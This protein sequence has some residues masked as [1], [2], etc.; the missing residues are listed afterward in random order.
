MRAKD[1]LTDNGNNPEIHVKPYSKNRQAR[2]NFSHRNA[3]SV[4]LT[5]IVRFLYIAKSRKPRV[6]DT[7]ILLIS[8]YTHTACN[9]R[10]V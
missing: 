4:I 10:R 5:F 7:A 8:N 9:F 6:M 1:L 2:P 3:D